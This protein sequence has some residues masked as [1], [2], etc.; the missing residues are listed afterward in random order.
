[1]QHGCNE[2]FRN[3]AIFVPDF[4]FT[5]LDARAFEEA[6]GSIERPT[7]AMAMVTGNTST[8]CSLSDS[9][10]IQTTTASNN[11]IAGFSDG[12]PGCLSFVK[13]CGVFPSRAKSSTLNK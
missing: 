3:K 6:S 9:T 7:S 1:V 4:Y 5:E 8:G 10:L 11:Q 12:R 13:G 2:A